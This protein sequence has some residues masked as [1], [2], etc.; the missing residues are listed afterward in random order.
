MTIIHANDPT[1]QFLS[2]IYNH[3]EDIKL[4]VTEKCTN[5]EVI[6]AIRDDDT[7]MMLGH[8]SEAGLCSILRSDGSFERL[9][10]NSGHVQF[11]RGKTCIGIWCKANQFAKDYKLRGLFSGM[12]ISELYEADKEHVATT[13]EEIDREMLKFATRLRDCINQYDLG[14]IPQRLRELDDVG[15]ELTRFNYNNLFYIE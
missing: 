13:Q 4:H 14:E 6:R 8:G 11:L 12:I 5:M 15:S 9:I 10:I 3:R 7:I 2:V 1:T